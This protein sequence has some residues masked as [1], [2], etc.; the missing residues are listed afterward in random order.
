[1]I[2][3]IEYER[4]KGRIVTFKQFNDSKRS[5]AETLRL[6]IE[7]DLGRKGINHEVVLLDAESEAALRLTHRRYFENVSQISRSIGMH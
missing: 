6:R 7:L 4:P 2:F 3:L 5:H 1:M